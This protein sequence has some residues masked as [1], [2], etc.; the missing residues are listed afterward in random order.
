VT[1]VGT[2]ALRAPSVLPRTRS[3]ILGSGLGHNLPE[4]TAD[5][6]TTDSRSDH[7]VVNGSRRMDH[8]LSPSLRFEGLAM[9]S[10]LREL[11]L[12]TI[13]VH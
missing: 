4:A 1:A 12:G 6:L 10:N 13:S 2:S 11:A 7:T 5:S 9:H 8:P 3:R